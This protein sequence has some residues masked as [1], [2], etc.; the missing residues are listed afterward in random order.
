MMVLLK[1]GSEF[2]TKIKSRTNKLKMQLM[3]NSRRGTKS[4]KSINN[5]KG[6]IKTLVNTKNIKDTKTLISISRTLFLSKNYIQARDLLKIFY[7]IILISDANFKEISNSIIPFGKLGHS[8]SKIGIS[9]NN[10]N[11]VIKLFLNKIDINTEIIVQDCLK[12]SNRFNEIF[13]NFIITH[14]DKLISIPPNEFKK[15]KYHSLPL[16]DYG[17]SNLGSYITIPL[18]GLAEHPYTNTNPG[19]FITNLRELLE[20]NHKEYLERAFK[21]NRNDILEEYDKFMAIKIA[22]YIDVIRILQNRLTYFNSDIKLTNIFIK[23]DNKKYNNITT[24]EKT[25]EDWGFITNFKCIIS[26]LE[27]SSIVINEL[28]ITTLPRSQL[29]ITIA[30]LIDKGLIYDLRYGCKMEMKKC[31]M[32]DIMDIDILTLI[33]DYYAFML[34]INSEFI[35]RMSIIKTMFKKYI[36]SNLLNEI[37]VILEKGKYKIDKNYSYIIGNILQTLCSKIKI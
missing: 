3:K 7:N 21:E 1:S 29:K 34:R 6:Q 4:R 24:K 37:Q 25:L 26:D 27:K 22:E 13:I 11:Q 15:V 12:I 23:K 14:L 2:R 10:S 9:R 35:S 8:G 5:I 31:P 32:L 36:E 30:R 19:K 16:L 18:I 20:L 28:K 17:I 33:I